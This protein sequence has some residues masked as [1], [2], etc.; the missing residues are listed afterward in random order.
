MDQHESGIAQHY[1]AY[2]VLARIRDGLRAM[3]H[4]PDHISPDVLKPVDEFHIGGAEA[5]RALLDKL[6]L[7]PDMDILDIGCG[8]GGPAR[9]I[10]NTIDADVV[11]IDL[12]PP[13]VETATALS[14]MC[15]MS[16]RVRFEVA[17][18]TSLPFAERCFDVATLLHVGMNIP[19]KAAVFREAE[20]VL[21]PGG[22][23][24]VYDVMRTGET[25][26]SYPVP[27]AETEDLSALEPPETY[28][29][30]AAEV[31]L[32]LEAEENRRAIALDFFA[33]VRA[34]AA[35]ATPAPLGLHLL[36]GPTVG[37]KTANMIAAIK[38]EAIAPVQM[39]FRKG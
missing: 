28:R 29:N 9:A 30:A 19:D 11:G 5:T 16:E 26:L 2:D 34:Q 4:D 20:R 15:G 14:A 24:A 8:I 7:R 10:A 1:S 32:I 31:G 37:T 27:W 3:G 33:R 21:R 38:A 23:F 18:A 17:S 22:V 39:L 13:F 36:M 25:P 35:T 6:A 12:T